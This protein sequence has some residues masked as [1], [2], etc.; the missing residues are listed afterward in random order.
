MFSFFSPGP[1]QLLIVLL[2]ILAVIMPVIIRR[3]RASRDPAAPFY[4]ASA[5]FLY[6]LRESVKAGTDHL[7]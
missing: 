5:H 6:S 1:F 4:T 2:I 7:P 3:I